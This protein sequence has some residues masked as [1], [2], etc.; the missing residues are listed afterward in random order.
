MVATGSTIVFIH[1]LRNASPFTLVRQDKVL[2]IQVETV[3]YCII[4]D[5]SCEP[6][7]LHQLLPWEI[8]LIRDA[9]DLAR[10]IV[11][12]PPFPTENIQAQVIRF[13]VDVGL[14]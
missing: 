10:R 5:A 1:A 3:L 8:M 4:I 14:Q 12:L 13:T 7:R 9:F 2:L 11:L 6:A